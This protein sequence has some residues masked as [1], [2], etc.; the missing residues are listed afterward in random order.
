M[1]KHRIFSGIEKL[2]SKPDVKISNFD[3]VITNAV[4]NQEKF[5]LRRQDGYFFNVVNILPLTPDQCT[6]SVDNQNHFHPSVPTLLIGKGR[7]KTN[8]YPV[9]FRGTQDV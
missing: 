9:K 3:D 4:A 5:L 2:G 8:K 6:S 1:Y 7:R